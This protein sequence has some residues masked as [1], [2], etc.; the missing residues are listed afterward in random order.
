MHR[1]SSNGSIHLV[2]DDNVFTAVVPDSTGIILK[3]DD[4][5]FIELKAPGDADAEEDGGAGAA[6]HHRYAYQGHSSKARSEK[7][8]GR[9]F[10]RT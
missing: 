10:G 8:P 4:Y 3:P 1:T 2:Y 7:A 9:R 6:T 5:A